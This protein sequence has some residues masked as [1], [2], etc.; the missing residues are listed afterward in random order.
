M[1]FTIN[2]AFSTQSSYSPYEA[3]TGIHMV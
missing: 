2:V 1:R 3:I